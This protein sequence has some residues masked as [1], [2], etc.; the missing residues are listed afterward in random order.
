ML[1]LQLTKINT[2]LLNKDLLEERKNSTGCAF[3]SEESLIYLIYHL[4]IR[5]VCREKLHVSS[6]LLGHWCHGSL[7]GRMDSDSNICCE[8]HVVQTPQG[9]KPATAK[10]NSGCQNQA[11][12]PRRVKINEQRNMGLHLSEWHFFTAEQGRTRSLWLLHR[13]AV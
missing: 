12:L 5:F 1:H 13:T 7:I 2:L 10:H 8:K 4:M 11:S 3:L 6:P 9:R